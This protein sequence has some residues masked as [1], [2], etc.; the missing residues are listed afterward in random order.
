M[1][2]QTL[3]GFFHGHGRRHPTAEG[4]THDHRL[5][6]P[7][8]CRRP[9]P[10]AYNDALPSAMPIPEPALAGAGHAVVCHHPE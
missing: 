3:I 8:P 5:F 7:S 4:S 6:S 10:F 9:D 1:P 2:R